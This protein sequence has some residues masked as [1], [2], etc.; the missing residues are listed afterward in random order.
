MLRDLTTPMTAKLLQL[1]GA[2]VLLVSVAFALFALRSA[3]HWVL[4]WLPFI[5]LGASLALLGAVLHAKDKGN[6]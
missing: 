5:L 6:P 4:R 3:D 1:A 2:L